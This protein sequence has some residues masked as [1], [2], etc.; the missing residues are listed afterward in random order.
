MYMHC[1]VVVLRRVFVV[2]YYVYVFVLCCT[3]SVGVCIVLWCTPNVGVCIV[4]CCT[5]GVGVCVV[6]QV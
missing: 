6:C 3:P 1:V 4:L 2:L 5:L